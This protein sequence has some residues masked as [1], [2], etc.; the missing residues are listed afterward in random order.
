MNTSTAQNCFVAI[1][2]VSRVV[3]NFSAYLE[4][5]EE[6]DFCGIMEDVFKK[7]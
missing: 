6:R 1:Y 3:N 2:I 7:S 4:E 5:E